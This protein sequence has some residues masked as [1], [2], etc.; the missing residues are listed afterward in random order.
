MKPED[1]HIRVNYSG[2]CWEHEVKDDGAN[3]IPLMIT[4]RLLGIEALLSD[5]AHYMTDDPRKEVMKPY[6]RAIL[7]ATEEC[8]KVLE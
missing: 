2:D 4:K 7:A 3:L 8:H 1:I 6:L 5:I